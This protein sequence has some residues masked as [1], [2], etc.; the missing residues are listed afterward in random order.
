[1]CILVVM[2]LYILQG[3][4]LGVV[5]VMPLYLA[6]SGATWK[7]QGILSF[8]MYPFTIK[9]LWAP[10]IDVFYIRRLGRRQTWLLPV[11]IIL[12]MTFIILSFYLESLLAQLRV[13][14]L[15][16]ILF[17]IIFLT[18]TQD[19]CVDGWALTLFSSSNLVWQSI[20]QMI[21][22]PLG[23]FL[24]SPILLTFESANMTNKLIRYPLGLV[25]QSQ[26]LFT[27]PQFVRFWGI[28]FL[29]TT[30]AVT[31]LFR[32]Q[33]QNTN[34]NKK[35]HDD[36]HLNLLETYM[37]IVRLFKKKCFRQFILILIGP[38]VGYA[39]TSAMTYITLIR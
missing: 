15:T 28:I 29:F 22:S 24:G 31:L 13:I 27:L 18:A 16:I 9:L 25:D 34:T 7:Q 26:G 14:K 4:T 10:F 5:S 20:S 23:Y 38:H 6:S 11:Q 33:Q 17:F 37:Y 39:A 8:V 35:D 32:Q 36:S 1:M 3:I 2:V 19:I 12:G 30:C 21:G